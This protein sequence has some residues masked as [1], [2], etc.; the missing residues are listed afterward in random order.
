MR[1]GQKLRG[2]NYT[3]HRKEYINIVGF[4]PFFI[5]HKHNRVDMLDFSWCLLMYLYALQGIVLGLGNLFLHQA[6]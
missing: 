4:H 3:W 6:K 5:S 2:V 1:M